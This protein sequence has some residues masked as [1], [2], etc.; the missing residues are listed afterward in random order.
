MYTTKTGRKVK[1]KVY[2]RKLFFIV[3]N[4]QELADLVEN[5]LKC[6]T[7]SKEKCDNFLGKSETGVHLV[8]HI[9]T[10]L[11][12]QCQK[13]IKSFFVVI[14][15]VILTDVTL[16]KTEMESKEMADPKNGYNCVAPFKKID[17]IPANNHELRYFHSMVI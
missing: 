5:G 11:Y 13:R 8:K 7:E 16:K 6:R 2:K 9:D 14:A 1:K 12:Y 4:E 15:E 3:E 17:E 10:L